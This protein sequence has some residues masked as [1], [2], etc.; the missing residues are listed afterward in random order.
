MRYIRY[1]V[2]LLLNT[3][4]FWRRL[5]PLLSPSP[6]G[7][8]SACPKAEQLPSPWE[9]WHMSYL[10]RASLPP[11]SQPFPHAS[12]TTVFTLDCKLL[13]QQLSRSLQVKIKAL[14]LPCNSFPIGL[15]LRLL[16]AS[17]LPQNRALVS[18]VSLGQLPHHF[19]EFIYSPLSVLSGK[20]GRERRIWKEK[21]KPTKLPK[22]F[23]WNMPVNVGKLF[24]IFP[25]R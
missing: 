12:L 11:L 21:K 18:Q 25:Q 1:L 17:S 7:F 24:D 22:R 6:A 10:S 5:A 3:L 23:I 9:A 2:N 14:S 8:P 16:L 13:P 4:N 19:Q 15:W 20:G